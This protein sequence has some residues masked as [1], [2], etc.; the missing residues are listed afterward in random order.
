MTS[1]VAFRRITITS[2]GCLEGHVGCHGQFTGCPIQIRC[3]LITHGWLGQT[4]IISP[5]WPQQQ[6]PQLH[7]TRH[8]RIDP[9]QRIRDL[10]EIHDFMPVNLYVRSLS[11]NL[12]PPDMNL[13][14]REQYLGSKYTLGRGV[15][16]HQCSTSVRLMEE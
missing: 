3:I 12:Y 16:L 15:R 10:N 9:I 13:V 6:R 4:D 7:T 8:E 1:S 14:I 2:L 11:N 5:A